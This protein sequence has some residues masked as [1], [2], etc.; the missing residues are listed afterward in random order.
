[1]C[2]LCP[3]RNPRESL[4]PSDEDL[5]GVTNYM[6]N[7]TTTLKKN[8]L[9]LMAVVGIALLAAT[10]AVAGEQD[11][12]LHNKTGV[13]IDKLY[14]APHSSNDWQEDILGQDTLANGESL[15]IRFGRSEKAAHWDIRIEDK[16]G[17]SVE[18]ESLNL[19][20]ISSVTLYIKDG[21]AW[22]EYD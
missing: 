22:A 7:I 1:M 11:F 16:Q 13:A 21:K 12:I 3:I 18:W 17:H 4:L 8:T 20:E 5:E 15:K 14:I 19:L 6:Q 2:G 9:C 10:A